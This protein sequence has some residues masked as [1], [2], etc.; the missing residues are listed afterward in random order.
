MAT[1]WLF[2]NR[3][4]IRRWGAGPDLVWIH[5]LGESSVSFDPIARLMPS[6]R[7]TLVDLPGYGRSRWDDA[8][9]SLEALAA[10]LAGW[11][12]TQRAV[13][14]GHSMGGVLGTMLGERGVARGVVNIDGNISSG[15]CVFSGKAAAFS[16]DDFRAHGFAQLRDAVYRDGVDKPP[17][18]GYAA[19]MCFA[20]PDVFWGHARDLVEMSAREDLA[21]RFAALTVPALYLAG[22]PDGVCARSKQLLNEAGANW[23]AVAPAGHW[24]YLDQ[25]RAFVAAVEAWFTASCN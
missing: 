5:G 7:H 6:F 23:Q 13:V 22:D 16:K 14:I 25:P 9:E 24:V 21:A 15:D 11:L 19:A 10:R 2:E 8:P 4:T 17:L 20:S 18:R 12:R 1:S 3:M